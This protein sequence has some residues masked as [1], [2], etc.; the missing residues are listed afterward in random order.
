MPSLYFQTSGN[1]PNSIIG[2]ALSVA[3]DFLLFALSSRNIFF[4]L[5]ST[6]AERRRRLGPVNTEVGRI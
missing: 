3:I 5:A 1:L 4:S 2:L 6:I